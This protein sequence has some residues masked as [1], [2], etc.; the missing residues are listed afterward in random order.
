MSERLE[1]KRQAARVYSHLR[2]SPAPD[3]PV[4]LVLTYHSVG[5]GPLAIRTDVFRQQMGWLKQNVKVVPLDELLK[6][7]TRG[8]KSGIVCAIT[9]DDGYASIHR[10]A[11]PILSEFGFGATV[12]LVV[13]ALDADERKSSN[14]INGLYPDEDML[15]WHEALELQAN[16]IQLGSHLIHHNDLTALDAEAASAELAGS[17]M[18][19]EDKT[20]APCTSFCYPWGKHD[21]RSVEAVSAAGYDN[22][23]T[24]VQDR[25]N[26]ELQD[27]FRIPRAD[28][29]RDYTIDDFA[30]VV[31]GDWDYLGY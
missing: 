7:Q 11:M 21:Q 28:V 8:S 5:S 17:K 15:L 25:W 3:N 24:E 22:A 13:G 9:F 23:V 10:H 29:R 1:W 12:Y 2:R 31:R 20:G 6:G 18:L 14:Q 16:R 19:I 26:G 4:S 30:S 27:R